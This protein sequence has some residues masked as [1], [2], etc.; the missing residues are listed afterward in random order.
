MATAEI[1]S[2][3]SGRRPEAWGWRAPEP[4][5]FGDG[6]GLLASAELFNPGSAS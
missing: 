4:P 3:D 5:R 6:Y 2:R 1:P